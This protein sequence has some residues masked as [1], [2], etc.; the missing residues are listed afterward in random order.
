MPQTTEG[1]T[2]LSQ[3]GSMNV[4]GGLLIVESTGVDPYMQGPIDGPEQH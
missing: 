3:I 2:P 1:W 4:Q